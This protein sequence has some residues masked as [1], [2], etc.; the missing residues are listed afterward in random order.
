MGEGEHKMFDYF[1]MM[2]HKSG[3][4]FS[5]FCRKGNFESKFRIL[6]HCGIY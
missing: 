3:T 2:A 5:L 4:P 1:V 6:H